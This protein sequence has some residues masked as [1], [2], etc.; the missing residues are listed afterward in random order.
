MLTALTRRTLCFIV[1]A[2][3]AATFTSSLTANVG[4]KTTSTTPTMSA[5]KIRDNSPSL[6][7]EVKEYC[8][9]SCVDELHQLGF[10]SV[11]LK[12]LIKERRE[13]G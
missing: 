12:S 8:G 6:P 5:V 7:I 9:N 11:V 13:T 4:A 3:K 2:D 10:V 1:S